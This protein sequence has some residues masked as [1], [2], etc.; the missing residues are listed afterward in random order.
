MFSGCPEM[1]VGMKDLKEQEQT[2]EVRD[3]FIIMIVA[4]VSHTSKIITL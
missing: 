2:L 4:V 3:V 1:G